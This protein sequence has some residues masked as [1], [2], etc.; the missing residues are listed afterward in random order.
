M[1]Y[2]CATIQKT[3]A[4][5]RDTTLNINTHTVDATLLLQKSKKQ[6]TAAWVLLGGGAGLAIAGMSI[7]SKDASNDLSADLTTIFTLGF[8]APEKQKHSA[9][10]PILAIAGSAAM[11][12][13]IPLFI[14]AGK[15]KRK[16]SLMLINENVFFSPRLNVKQNLI[17]AGI[18]IPL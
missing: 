9:A 1:V 3:N 7:I 14:S 11:L 6:K 18:R 12:G 16:A 4:Q 15:N 17:A 8:V 2:F 10:G 13:S 5:L